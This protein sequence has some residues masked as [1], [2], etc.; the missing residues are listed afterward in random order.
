MNAF[1]GSRGA[2]IAFIFGIGWGLICAVMQ[3]SVAQDKNPDDTVANIS[4]FRQVRRIFQ[5][6]CLGCHQP[7]KDSGQYLMTEFG[8]LLA[9]GSSGDAA[10]IPGNPDE[11]YLVELI[12]PVDGH[13]EM[14]Q[15]APPLSDPD[16]Q[17]IRRWIE[18]GAIDDSPPTRQLIDAQNPPQYMRYPIVTA[19]DVSRDGKYLAVSGI[20][21][22]T[23]V[24]L[25]SGVSVRRLI[26]RS[27]RIE[28]ISFSPDNLRL[29]VTGGKP[30]EFGEVQIWDVVTGEL[31]VS[32]SVTGDTLFG[33]S[34]SPDGRLVAFGSTDNTVRAL[35]SESG[36]QVLFQNVAEDWIRDTVFS[37]DGTHLISVGRDM[38]CKLTEVATERFV[39]NITSITP[40][41]LKGG[42]SSVARHPSRDEIVVGS[43]DGIPKLYRVFRETKRVIGDDANLLRE[44]PQMHGRI[45]AVA[46]SPDGKRIAVTSGI[47]GSSEIRVFGYE[48]DT[49][50]PDDIKAIN[51][52]VVTGRT[53]EENKRLR[54]FLTS[55]LV[56]QGSVR[57]DDG[58]T[59][60]LTFTGDGSSVIAA[61]SSGLIREFDAA[62]GALRRSL[63]AFEL[64][65]KE[66]EIV[67][68]TDALRLP[69]LQAEGPERATISE[70]LAPIDRLLV[71]PQSLNFQTAG[72]YVQMAVL[73]IHA[74]GTHRDVTAL[75]SYSGAA[76][77]LVYV[78]EN[79]LVEP[80][81]EGIGELI[82]QFENLSTR[83]PVA[84]RFTAIDPVD[85]IRDVNPVLGKLGCN[86][87]TCH[88]SQNG[89]RGFKLSLRGYDPLFDVRGLTDDLS[90]RRVNVAAPDESL[91]LLKATGQVPHEG[92]ALIKPGD[93]YYSLIRAWIADGAKLDLAAAKVASITIEPQL[94]VLADANHRQQMRVVANY[95]DGSSRDVTR[96]AFIESADQE[97]A[98]TNSAGQ[99]I[100]RRRGESAILARYEGAFAAT[101]LT[102]MG[103]RSDFS[104]NE[105]PTFNEIDRLVARKW[106]RMKILPSDL[107]SDTEFLR[108]VYL[109]LTGLPPNSDTVKAF[110]ADG[111][112]TQEKRNSVIDSLIGSSDFVDHWTNKWADLLQV[113]EKFLAAEG[114]AKFH[115]WIREQVANNVPYD[116][117]VRSVM[118]ATGS[119]AENPAAAYFK[120]LRTPEDLMENTTH[121]FLATRFNCNK[122]HDHPFEKWTQDQYY[123][124]AAFFAQIDRVRD[125]ASGD[126]S[127]GGTD[128]VSATPLFEQISDSAIGDVIHDRTKNVTAPAFPFDSRITPAP[129]LPRREQFAAWLTSPENPYFASSFANRIWGY[130]LGVGLIEPIDDIRASNPPTNPQLLAFLTREL[131]DHNF[132]TRH[133]IRTICQ[134][135]VYQLSVATNPLNEDDRS[136]YS[137]ALPRRLPAEVL[138]DTLYQVTGSQTQFPGEQAGR[139][140]AQLPD[141][142]NKLPSGLL[143]ALGKPV[144]ESACECERGNDLH[145]GSILA[146][147]SGPDQATAINDPTNA[148]AQLTNSIS[149]N[150]ELVNELFFRILNRP[151]TADEIELSLMAFNDIEADHKRLLQTRDQRADEMKSEYDRIEQER[152]AELLV[153]NNDLRTFIAQ[154]DPELPQREQVRA[155][156]LTRLQEQIQQFDASIDQHLE[157]WRAD[158][159]STIQWHP[160][161]AAEITNTSDAPLKRLADHSIRPMESKGKTETTVIALTDLSRVSAV[162]LEALAADDL[163]NR[164]PGLAENG[165]FVISEFSVEMASPESPDQWQPL[166]LKTPMADFFQTS[167]SADKL[168]DGDSINGGWAVVPQV[169]RTHWVTFQLESP[170]APAPGTRLRFKLHQNYDDKHQIGRFRISLSPS[171]QS[172]G[173]SVS[174]ELLES[175]AAESATWTEAQRNLFRQLL[176]AGSPI[177]MALQSDLAATEQPLAVDPGIVRRRERVKLLSI[178]TPRDAELVR[179][180]KDLAQSQKQLDKLRLTAAQDLSWA[181]INSPAFLFNH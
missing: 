124:T 129:D 111:R 100:A 75:C 78:N 46:I 143:A 48:F 43:A 66:S 16:V 91:M 33:V 175:L 12:T 80:R 154:V 4:F 159:L 169:G 132:D 38:T 142:G 174:D 161:L 36:K 1:L 69:V 81:R 105:P 47:D 149:D 146:M 163:P 120:I 128:V 25:M 125:P 70:N 6:H 20:Q 3:P 135:R 44:F 58:A 173:V 50:V 110:L 85:F 99:S 11:S 109:D 172:V 41:V 9:G 51:S 102:V 152:L 179:L 8:S 95:S 76:E 73:A 133:L 64:S 139:R 107:C 180:E 5:A 122:C 84:C 114:A 150:R 117:F 45:Q 103:L 88:G 79:Q 34:W 55:D 155:E 19:L 24:D 29:A 168:I 42:I 108:R 138:F 181:L 156:K 13:A 22:V 35:E 157:Q 83:V 62:T 65:A 137:H 37:A 113:N 89:K 130:L 147:V 134:S 98:T 30:G 86:A 39:D 23:L 116:Q 96:E 145:L 53:A 61:G 74:D 151:A 87:G 106:E 160:V 126:R 178:V 40:G 82:V 131:V 77:G 140:A 10:I 115:A 121:L 31:L 170:L 167:F 136:N 21:E 7:A 118:T 148:I 59:Y 166:K 119:N 127:I 71:L 68:A 14:P 101:T 26:G 32:K 63:Q 123:Q 18:Q 165:N 92:G 112:P 72:E 56:E 97:V 2:R 93:K 176:R 27:P 57:I 104:W 52:K 144:R 15:H 153:A 28:S 54:E 162:R 90:S 67:D 17:R 60:A 164:G 171:L 141:A 49:N 177:L 158:H 94:P